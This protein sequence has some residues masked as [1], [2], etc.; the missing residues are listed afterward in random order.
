MNVLVLGGTRFFGKTL[1]AQL[2]AAGHAVTVLSRGKLPPPAGA[3]HLVADRADPAALRDV[4]AGR[5]FDAV[6]DNVAMTAAH[7]RSA[8]DALGDRVGHYLLTSSISAYGEFTRG[9]V[10]R[11]SELGPAELGLPPADGHPYTIGKRAAELELVKDPRPRVPFTIVRPGFVVGPHDHLRRAQFFVRRVLDGGPLVIPSGAADIFQLAWHAD[12]AAAF[13]H[14]LGDAATFGRTYNLV[15]H[16]LFT[17]PTLVRALAEATGLAATCVEVPRPLLRRGALAQQEL[18]FGEDSSCWAC[19]PARA[20][21]DLGVTPTPAV[22]W[23]AELAAGPQPAP[24]PAEEAERAAEL[25]CAR[26]LRRFMPAAP[27]RLRR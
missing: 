7:V 18:P 15:G 19:D 11:E 1:V 5:S 3:E 23:L 24:T 6:V 13:A 16:E 2:L 22:K 20:D 21:R 4:L 9:R 27:S 8:L 25:A 26:G 17:Y 12:V 14:A 10:W